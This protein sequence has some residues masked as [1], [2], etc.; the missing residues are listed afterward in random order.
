MA[1]HNCGGL[2]S[3]SCCF[4]DKINVLDCTHTL[5]YIYG[6]L[7]RKG[8][9]STCTSSQ[10]GGYHAYANGL[11]TQVGNSAAI[12]ASQIKSVE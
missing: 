1:S 4:S 7:E 5:C 11:C 12:P 6:K 10:E 2:E 8:P 3:S 9:R